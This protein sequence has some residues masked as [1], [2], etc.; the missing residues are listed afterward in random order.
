MFLTHTLLFLMQQNYPV[1][2]NF[3]KYTSVLME[4]HF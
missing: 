4:T 3:A 2:V 1:H